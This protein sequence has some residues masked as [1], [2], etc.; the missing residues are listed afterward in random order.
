M[1]MKNKILKSVVL[2]GVLL[3]ILGEMYFMSSNLKYGTVYASTN[4]EVIVYP[5]DFLYF[6]SVTVQQKIL[7]MI[8]I[9]LYK[10]LPQTNP[11]NLE[12]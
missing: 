7:N 9:H 3:G 8:P 5:K 1:K 6:F 11:H 4:R 2:L 12:M 10:L